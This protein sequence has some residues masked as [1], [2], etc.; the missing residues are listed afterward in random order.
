MKRF[1]SFFLFAGGIF[2]ILGCGS[3]TKPSASPRLI[4]KSHSQTPSWILTPPKPD[5]T[6]VY[7]VGSAEKQTS[8]QVAKKASVSDATRQ[9]VDYIGIRVTRKLSYKAVGTEGDNVSSLQQQIEESIEGKGNATVSIEISDIYYEKYDNG[10]YTMYALIKLPK[11]WVETERERQR[12]LIEQQRLISKK[13]LSDA[14]SLIQQRLYQPA[15][16]ALWQGLLISGKAAEN[17]DIYEEIRTQLI[18][19]YQRLSLQLISSPVYAYTEGGSDPII[20]RVQDTEKNA[21]I[22]GIA[23]EAIAEGGTLI[24]KKGTTTD[25]QGT[26]TYEVS[27]VSA[28]TTLP[29]II[30]FSFAAYS[31]VIASDTEL[32]NQ[33]QNIKTKNHLEISLKV[34]PR[35][36]AQATAVILLRGTRQGTKSESYTLDE[37]TQGILSSQLATKGFNVVEIELPNLDSSNEKK[38]KDTILAHLR[39]KYPHIRRLLYVL[40]SG[41]VLGNA[42]DIVK[43]DALSGLYVSEV[44]LSYVWI[45]VVANKV[46]EGKPLRGKGVGLNEEQA[47]QNSIKNAIGALVSFLDD[48]ATQKK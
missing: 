23:L 32:Q 27:Q 15:I 30:S 40:M 16:E 43:M 9:L 22:S 14:Q 38:I 18:S 36:K 1:L 26:L 37:A 24:A 31:N 20:A 33:I 3:S 45:D 46:E 17:E 48:Q 2:L 28:K 34:S 7:F 5:T 6:Y 21:P 35:T 12:K 41:N 8:L 13:Y 44:D 29:V 42:G 47:L 4:E 11:K 19:L 10:T 39:S 25:S